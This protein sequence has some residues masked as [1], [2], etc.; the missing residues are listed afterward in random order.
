MAD[1]KEKISIE[2]A[3]V[4]EGQQAI[5]LIEVELGTTVVEA[6]EKSNVLKLFPEID[7]LEGRVGIFGKLVTLTTILKE[8][9]RVEIYRFL[10][11]DPKV[12]RRMRAQNTKIK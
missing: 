1:N 3:Y 12:A 7:N 10:K 4:G 5:I 6:I 11:I 9:D 8:G 2:V